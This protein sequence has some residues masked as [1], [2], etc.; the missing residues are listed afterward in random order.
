MGETY[1]IIYMI[2]LQRLHGKKNYLFYREFQM[3]NVFMI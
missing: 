1:I 3:G 2:I